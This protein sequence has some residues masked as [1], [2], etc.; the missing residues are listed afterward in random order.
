MAPRSRLTV[1]PLAAESD[2]QSTFNG[3]APYANATAK[4]LPS[5]DPTTTSLLSTGRTLNT[6]DSVVWPVPNGKILGVTPGSP[7]R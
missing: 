5:T 6:G 3:G 7:R 1:T 4:P 2:A